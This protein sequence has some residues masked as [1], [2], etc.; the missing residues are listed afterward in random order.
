ML[1]ELFNDPKA[2]AV[3]VVV[4]VVLVQYQR[5]LSWTEYKQIHKFKLKLLPVIDRYTNLFVVSQKGG[6]HDPEYV[7]TTAQTLPE[8]FA[9]LVDGNGSPHLINAL[10][11]RTQPDT[12]HIQYSGAQVVFSH[13]DGAQTEVYLFRRSDER[14]D[15]Y[16]HVEP[17]VHT[18]EDHLEGWQQNGD[19]RGVIPENFF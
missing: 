12:G 4:L 5:T 3:L 15:V 10:K 6:V 19:A 16:A 14:T 17:G 2:Y 7:G 11:R 1:P 13:S 18:P 8:A 9:G